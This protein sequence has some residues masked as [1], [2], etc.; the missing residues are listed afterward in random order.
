MSCLRVVCPNL[1]P[2]I[3]TKIAYTLMLCLVLEKFK[4]KYEK[5]KIKKNMRKIKN[6]E[7]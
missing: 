3:W 5:K 1:N 7:K 4:R 2:L 6:K